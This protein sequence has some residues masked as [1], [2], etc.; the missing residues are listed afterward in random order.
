MRQTASYIIRVAE[1]LTA[2]DAS[3]FEG[4]TLYALADS[5]TMLLTPPID[6]TGLHGILAT[7]RDLAI[8]LIAICQLSAPPSRK[9][10]TPDR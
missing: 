9:E 7:L 8:P 6:Q 4:L 5:Q 1:P 3:W 2:A 10:T